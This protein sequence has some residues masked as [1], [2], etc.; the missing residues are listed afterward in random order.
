[1]KMTPPVCP[2]LILPNFARN[3]MLEMA[4]NSSTPPE[5]YQFPMGLV[6]PNIP[7]R[8]PM[9]LVHQLPLG[10]VTPNIPVRSPMT[11]INQTPLGLVPPNIPVRS[12]MVLVPPNIP[13]RSP[14]IGINQTPLGLVLPNI[15]NRSPMV[16]VPPNIPVRSPTG[17]KDIMR[18][19]SPKTGLIAPRM[20]SPKVAESN[21]WLPPAVDGVAD[22]KILAM[23]PIGTIPM[24]PTATQRV[25]NNNIPVTPKRTLKLNIID[26]HNPLINAAIYLDC[27][28]PE[29][30][31]YN[32]V[33]NRMKT[34]SAATLDFNAKYKNTCRPLPN[35]TGRVTPKTF[36]ELL[37]IYENNQVYYQ[38]CLDNITMFSIDT[39]RKGLTELEQW[40]IC[41][42][43]PKSTDS[44]AEWKNRELSK[45]DTGYSPY[46]DP[47]LH[48]YIPT[49]PPHI[50]AIIRQF[51]LGLF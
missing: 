37:S 21:P 25:Y 8:S 36:E 22:I 7:N 5:V 41:I 30:R 47:E 28:K 35:V 10:L 38:D 49:A 24:V 26:D 27:T 2:G 48:K 17:N 50:I 4:A 23:T 13:N 1:M 44:D 51:H 9:T 32:F 39:I 20:F 29:D 42:I 45:I 6:A 46:C 33:S 11:G 18:G 43:E 12:P 40:F 31:D 3:K 34:I 14:T 15:P 16:L 19:A